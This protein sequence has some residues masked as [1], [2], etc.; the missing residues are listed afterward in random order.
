MLLDNGWS[1][2][3]QGERIDR[4][5]EAVRALYVQDGASL[6][7][8]SWQHIS[9]VLDVALRISTE[10]GGDAELIAAA[11]LTHDLNY[12]VDPGSGAEEGQDVRSK[13]LR[14]S[15][16]LDDECDRIERIVLDAETAGREATISPEAMCLSDGDTLFKSLPIVPVLL[17]RE[18]MSELNVGLSELTSKVLD[19]QLPIFEAGYY[20]YS[21]LAKEY[22]SWAEGNLQLWRNIAE[23]LKS[24][25]V[26]EL[27]K[28]NGN[29]PPS[30]S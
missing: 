3:P 21:E 17:A 29:P 2:E 16:F 10:L 14:E 9:F 28:S 22:G 30:P 27:V 4:L 26:I 11:S 25:V 13:L 15:G 18:Y 12:F 1:P 5:T 7:Y 23:A 19:E 20:F 24:D 6:R 8:H